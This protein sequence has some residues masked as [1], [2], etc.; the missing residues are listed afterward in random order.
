MESVITTVFE[1]LNQQVCQGLPVPLGKLSHDHFHK[2]ALFAH[3]HELFNDNPRQ[4]KRDLLDDFPWHLLALQRPDLDK[5]SEQ[6]LFHI[7][8]FLW[9]HLGQL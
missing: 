5:H 6:C 1:N 4:N 3:F 9:T 2:S 8:E 7:L